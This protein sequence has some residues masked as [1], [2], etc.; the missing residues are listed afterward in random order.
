M[1]GQATAYTIAKLK[2]MELRTRA[3]AAWDDEFDWRQFHRVVL[4]RGAVPLHVLEG[5]VDD[6]IAKGGGS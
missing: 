4:G 1:T 5:N 2:I 6:W 3:M